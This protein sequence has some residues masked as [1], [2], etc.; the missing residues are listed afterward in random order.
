MTIPP[1]ELASEVNVVVIENSPQDSL[2]IREALELW[3]RPRRLTFYQNGQEALAGL[4]QLAEGLV[5]P[6]L[7]LLDWNLQGMHGSTI[8][9]EIRQKPALEKCFLVVLT[10]SSSELDRQ[11]ATKLGANRFVTKAIALDDFFYSVLELQ[12]VV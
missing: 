3:T 10:S 7:V 6:T 2:L 5:G 9:R 1:A 11:L 12:S 4:R 8:L